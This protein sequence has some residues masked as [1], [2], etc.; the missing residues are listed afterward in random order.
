MVDKC[1]ICGKSVDVDRSA[2]SAGHPGKRVCLDCLNG[3]VFN[4]STVNEELEPFIKAFAKAV[5]TVKDE[6]DKR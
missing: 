2:A 4:M 6:W 5:K 1:V 3:L